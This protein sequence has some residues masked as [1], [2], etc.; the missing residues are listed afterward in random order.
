[1][2]ST[3]ITQMEEVRENISEKYN[4]HISWKGKKI[5]SKM[6]KKFFF[7]KWHQNSITTFNK[8][9]IDEDNFL[10]VCL[11]IYISAVNTYLPV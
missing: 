4:G 10:D 8:I 9:I 3:Q 2:F 6:T 7:I 5:Q 11:S 1:M